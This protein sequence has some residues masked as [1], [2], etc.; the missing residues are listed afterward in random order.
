MKKFKEVHS[1]SEYMAALKELMEDNKGKIMAFRGHSDENWRLKSSGERKDLKPSQ[2]HKIWLECYKHNYEALKQANFLDTVVILQHYKIPTMLL[3]W[4]YNAMVALYFATEQLSDKDGA[5]I[6]TFPKQIYEPDAE[7]TQNLSHYLQKI[8][9]GIDTRETEKEEVK[10]IRALNHDNNMFFNVSES[11]GR[12]QAQA[13]LFSMNFKYDSS[14][15]ALDAIRAEIQKSPDPL[16][17]RELFFWDHMLKMKYQMESEN[18]FKR[19]GSKKEFWDWWSHNSFLASKYD[20]VSRAIENVRKSWVREYA[21]KGDSVENLENNSMKIII[22]KDSKKAIQI[23]LAKLC[24]ISAR[25]MYPD[26]FGYSE[27]IRSTL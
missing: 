2:Y 12:V 7:E 3:D 23:D 19:Y 5:V 24:N 14:E 26:F 15:L 16:K 17:E 18:N 20:I 22:P 1:L 21:K 25:T 9:H 11:N 27:Y 6:V 4:T 13:G 10:L 8:Y